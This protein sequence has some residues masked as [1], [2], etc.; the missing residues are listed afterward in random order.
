MKYST[1]HLYFREGTSDVK[2]HMTW[3]T[4]RKR[5]LTSIHKY[6]S[7]RLTLTILETPK[8]DK[9]LAAAFIFLN[10]SFLY[11]FDNN[12]LISHIFIVSELVA[13]R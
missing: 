6:P 2:D 10:A 9:Q 1:C 4:T 5:C 7:S 13:L 12:T 11:N 8:T 3:N